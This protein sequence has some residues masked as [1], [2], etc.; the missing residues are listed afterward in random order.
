MLL[1]FLS[2]AS[3]TALFVSTSSESIWLKATLN[4]VFV[5][6]YRT[7]L[8]TFLDQ[9]CIITQFLFEHDPEIVPMIRKKIEM[10]GDLNGFLY[11]RAVRGVSESDVF[12]LLD[13]LV[14]FF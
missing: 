4:T 13:D 14:D 9:K 7:L 11:A 8:Y 10:I 1:H 6:L 5:I 12:S 2:S 3:S